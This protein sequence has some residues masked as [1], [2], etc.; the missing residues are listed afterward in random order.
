M[1]RTLPPC[2]HP[3]FE[4]YIG[5]MQSELRRFQIAGQSAS[6]SN[7]LS[8]IKRIRSQ[9]IPVQYPWAVTTH[10]SQGSTIENVYLNT[11][12]F[13]QAPNRRAL[14]YVGISRASKS[15]HTVRVPASRKEVNAR[16][17][18]ARAAYEDVAGES[19]KSVLR[20]LNVAT[21]TLTG[22]EIVTE[23]LWA[24]IADI[25]QEVE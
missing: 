7:T 19:Y 13:A 5:R 12:S 16:Y 21:G 14:L 24:R 11:F 25:K 3:Q 15:L 1:I 18:E 23:Y 10:K 2:Q 6:A 9:W 22:K 20:Y 4:N 17:R 8:E